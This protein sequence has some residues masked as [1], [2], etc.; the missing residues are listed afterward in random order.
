MWWE[1]FGKAERDLPAAQIPAATRQVSSSSA[2]ESE[3]SSRSTTDREEAP[4][5]SVHARHD[6]DA[7]A[8]PFP[9][10]LPTAWAGDCDCD[11]GKVVGS[12]RIAHPRMIFT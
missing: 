10:G 5:P 9:T 8:F 3:H 1:G 2:P 7:I 6:G 11:G 4:D 12:R